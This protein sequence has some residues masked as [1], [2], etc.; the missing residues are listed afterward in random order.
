M[1]AKDR[2]DLESTAEQVEQPMAESE[3]L[4]GEPTPDVTEQSR[5][6]YSHVFIRL[7]ALVFLLNLGF[8]VLGPAQIQIFERIYCDDW[9]DKHPTDRVTF[10]GGD[11]PESLCKIPQIQQQVSTLK[12][13][14]EF[15]NAAPG[16]VMSIPIGMLSDVYGRRLFGI[17]TVTSLFLNEL[18]VTAVVWFQGAVPLKTMWLSS[19]FT[20]FGGGSV[21]AELILVVS[22]LPC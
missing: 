13:W 12:G 6:D 3:A 20:F 22:Y 15:F 10:R 18:W 11:I 1:L 8:Q 17:A 21:G 14:G 9:Y 7:Y 16:L 5:P 19:I 4:L 2:V